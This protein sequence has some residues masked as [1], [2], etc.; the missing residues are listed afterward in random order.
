LV[1][2]DRVAGVDHPNTNDN[3]TRPTHHP[4][5]CHTRFGATGQ[6]AE[7]AGQAHRLKD[8]DG[9]RTGQ[10]APWK[11]SAPDE[12]KMPT[13]PFITGW[14]PGSSTNNPTGRNT[15]DRLEVMRET[16]P[17]TRVFAL[18]SAHHRLGRVHGSGASSGRTDGWGG[19]PRPIRSR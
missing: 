19:Q 4:R 11:T 3:Q 5:C 10:M 6:P 8:T 12:R 17:A 14:S 1:M 15:P 7:G 2:Y 13:G 16:D 9:S 18:P